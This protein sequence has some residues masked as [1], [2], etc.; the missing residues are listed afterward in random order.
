MIKDEIL[1]N[2]V[3]ILYGHPIFEGFKTNI[4]NE[5]FEFVKLEGYKVM[6]LNEIA[7]HYK[8]RI[9]YHRLK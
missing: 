6:T 9:K 7:N 5:I 1:K 3:A 8:N 2:N 4:L